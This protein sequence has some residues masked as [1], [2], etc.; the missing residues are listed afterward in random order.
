MEKIK[1]VAIAFWRL[2]KWINTANV[3]KKAAAESSLR[4]IKRFLDE[5]SIEI[6]DL[7][8]ETYDSGL[9]V[10]IVYSEDDDGSNPDGVAKITQMVKPIILQSGSVI[11][12][13]QA[14][15]G[16][17]LISNDGLKEIVI[18]DT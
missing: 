6:E 15:I 9:A 5:N 7:T 17:K 3:D 11:Q 1:D 14:I 4:S 8:G 2:E 10:E 16:S 18:T 13:G 12:F